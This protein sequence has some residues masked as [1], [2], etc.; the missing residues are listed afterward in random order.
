MLLLLPIALLL[1]WIVQRRRNTSVGIVIHAI[2]NA[3]GFIA[4]VSGRANL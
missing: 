1:P 4:A 3:A 2:F